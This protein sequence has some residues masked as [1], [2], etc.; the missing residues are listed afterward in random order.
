MDI[1]LDSPSKRRCYLN[2]NLYYEGLIPLDSRSLITNFVVYVCN[3]LN[4]KNKEKYSQTL[5]NHNEC[6]LFYGKPFQKKI[7][8]KGESTMSSFI[9]N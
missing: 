9:S 7:H 4:V 8:S 2:I 1:P 6:Q 3:K 5:T